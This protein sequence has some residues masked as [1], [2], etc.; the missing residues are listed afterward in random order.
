[1]PITYVIGSFGMTG[2]LFSVIFKGMILLFTD[3]G[4]VGP[5]IGQM[6][7]V[8]AQHEPDMPVIDLMHDVPVFDPRAG[9]Y[10]LAALVPE[11][12]RG[13]VVVGVVDP[14][15][16][17][18]RRAL[19]V[20]AD[21]RWFLGPDNGLFE[22]VMRRASQVQAFEIA[23]CP[24]RLSA[25]FHGRDLFAPMAARLSRGESED[26]TPLPEAEVRRP[27]WPDDWPVVIFCDHFGNVIT[28]LRASR[29]PGGTVL[30]AGGRRFE[31]L[32]TFSDAETGQGFWYENS[33]GL[34][35]IA[36][37]QG[38][39]SVLLALKPGDTVGVVE[40]RIS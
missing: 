18:A 1:M 31:R 11:M 27:D 25:S 13:A 22:L 30:E 5:Y 29:L 4:Y 17:S 23:W 28:G 12:A 26:L 24:S 35:E 40:P 8:L 19:A 14:G 37:N 20:K 21:G 9:A 3:F 10:L 16:G 34:A 39:A 6:K 38:N 32:R 7:A 33:D 2:S 36:I 15:V